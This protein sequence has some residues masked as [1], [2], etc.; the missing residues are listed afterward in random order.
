MYQFMFFFYVTVKLS[1][2]RSKMKTLVGWRHL[3]CHTAVTSDPPSSVCIYRM[4]H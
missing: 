2:V 1:D 4:V 3:H